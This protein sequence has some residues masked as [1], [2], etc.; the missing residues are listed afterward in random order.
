MVRIDDDYYV[1]WCNYYHGPTI[2]VACTKDFETFDQ[3][4]N[5]FLI[6][7][8]NGVLFPRRIDGLYMMLSRP[9]DNGHTPFG[10]IY[11]SQSPD[12]TFWGRHRLVLKVAPLRVE[13][14]QARGRAHPHRDQRGLAAHLPRGLPDL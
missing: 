14:H 12:M 9:S 3:M 7:N 4:E 11:L 6:F 10:D 1:T 13:E 5:A 2:G 8:R